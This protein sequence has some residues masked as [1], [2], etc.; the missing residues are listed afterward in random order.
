V[1]ENHPARYQAHHLEDGTIAA[2][3]QLARF[4]GRYKS[5][6]AR[7]R[8]ELSQG[9]LELHLSGAPPQ[10]L[11]PITAH[12]FYVGITPPVVVTFVEAPEGTVQEMRL[13]STR[14]GGGGL[15]VWER[16]K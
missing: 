6:E 2:E 14:V 7:T 10:S 16:I 1:A 15:Q 3:S 8:I 11:A 12:S 13:D 5:G 9:H 4:V